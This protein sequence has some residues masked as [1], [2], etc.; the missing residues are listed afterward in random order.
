VRVCVCVFAPKAAASLTDPELHRRR[1]SAK[2]NPPP[3]KTRDRCS[4]EGATAPANQPQR[5]HAPLSGVEVEVEVEAVE[6]GSRRYQPASPCVRTL[7]GAKDLLVHKLHAA[8]GYWPRSRRASKRCGEK[9]EEKKKKKKKKKESKKE[10]WCG[11]KGR[12]LWGGGRV[13]LLRRGYICLPGVGVCASAHR[14]TV[15]P[16]LREDDG[17]ERRWWPESG[18][19]TAAA[20]REPGCAEHQCMDSMQPSLPRTLQQR[21]RALRA[22]TAATPHCARAKTHVSACSR[23]HR[24]A[25]GAGRRNRA[26]SGAERA[27]PATPFAHAPHVSLSQLRRRHRPHRSVPTVAII[28]AVLA[29]RSGAVPAFFPSFR[30]SVLPSFLPSFRPSVLPS[31]L[32][33]FRPSTLVLPGAAASCTH[34]MGCFAMHATVLLPRWKQ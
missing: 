3:P 12:N 10:E 17:G 5:P 30:P 15:G 20:A 24:M 4:G 25:P 21:R 19:V 26:S 7:T 27:P 11:I 9:G 13:R 23:Q 29:V 33:S 18:D 28:A 2:G 14:C 16:Q 34:T 6:A 8:H 1:A 32:P 31:V 22:A